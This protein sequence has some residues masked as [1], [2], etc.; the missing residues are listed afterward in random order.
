MRRVA[1]R[2]LVGLV[3]AVDCD[4][5]VPKS[6]LQELK[7]GRQND[8]AKNHS[9]P[10]A[11]GEAQPHL[12]AWLLDDPMAVR[13]CLGLANDFQVATVTNV[14]SPKQELDRLID[15]HGPRDGASRAELLGKIASSIDPKRHAHAAQ[16]GFEAFVNEVEQEF[17]A[18]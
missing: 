1:E 17:T 13:L 8:R 15:E 9:F 14:S 3:A 11:I 12:E 6:R 7:Q 4:S 16:T 2:N 18:Q 10:T 5:A